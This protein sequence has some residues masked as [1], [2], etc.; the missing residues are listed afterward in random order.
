MEGDGLVEGD[1]GQDISSPTPFSLPQLHTSGSSSYGEVL[2]TIE[3]VASVNNGCC[4]TLIS[5][6]HF[7]SRIVNSFP[8]LLPARY[9]KSNVGAFTP[10]SPFAIPEVPLFTPRALTN[11]GTDK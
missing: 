8:M 9:L 3:T 10:T 5:L 4:Q 11:T 2:P 6:C 1:S 7:R